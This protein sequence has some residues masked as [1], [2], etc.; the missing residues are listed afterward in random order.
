MVWQ[1]AN[2][3]AKHPLRRLDPAHEGGIGL[4]PRWIERRIV[5]GV[6]GFL[7]KLGLENGQDLLGP[8]LGDREEARVRLRIGDHEQLGKPLRIVAGVVG[9][10]VRRQLMFGLGAGLFLEDR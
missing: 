7:G 6:R 4:R 8:L 5:P 9:E 2:R 3:S 10:D 1:K